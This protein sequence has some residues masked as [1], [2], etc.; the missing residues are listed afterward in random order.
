MIV[1]K[2]LSIFSGGS[3]ALARF[4]SSLAVKRC[5]LIV[6]A[7]IYSRRT[8]GFFVE[9]ID[10][11]SFCFSW[12]HIQPFWKTVRESLLDSALFSRLKGLVRR[13]CFFFMIISFFL[14][15]DFFVRFSQRDDWRTVFILIGLMYQRFGQRVGFSMES[16]CFYMSIYSSIKPRYFLLI[17]S[18]KLFRTTLYISSSR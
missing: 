14:W 1:V 13:G 10:D 16:A 2:S 11:R 6:R 9:F 4:M 5:S 17:S 8:A 18:L 7:G 12:T 15:I 3:A